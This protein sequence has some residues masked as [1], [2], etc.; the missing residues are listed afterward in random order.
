MTPNISKHI[1][2]LDLESQGKITYLPK[3]NVTNNSFPVACNLLLVRKYC[4]FTVAERKL[5]SG[6]RQYLSSLFKSKNIDK[7]F[8]LNGW[9]NNS[10]AELHNGL[11]GSIPKKFSRNFE[12]PELAT[13]IAGIRALD[14]DR[15]NL[16]LGHCKI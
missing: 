14:H 6:W 15:D 5:K 16:P 3:P 2:K 11:P 13:W 8:L 9:L 7:W 12:P 4:P 10:T 1:I